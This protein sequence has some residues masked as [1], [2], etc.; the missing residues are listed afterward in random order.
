MN[1]SELNPANFRNFD[2]MKEL[3]MAIRNDVRVWTWAARGWK[4][5]GNKFLQF[6]VSGHHHKGLVVLAVNGSDLFDIYFCNLRGE[7]KQEINDIYLE[8]LIETIDNKVERIPQYK[9]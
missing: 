3:Y 5:I 6:R 7:V 2:S 9:F 1:I 8:D 4:N